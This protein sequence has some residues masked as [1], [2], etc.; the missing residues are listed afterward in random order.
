[1]AREGPGLKSRSGLRSEVPGD[2]SAGSAGVALPRRSARLDRVITFNDILHAGRSDPRRVKL[3]RHTVKGKQVLE[4][5]RADRALVEGYQRRQPIGFFEGVDHAACFLASRDGHAVFGGLYR[6]EGSVPVP[7]DDRDPL[8]GEPNQ[9]RWAIFDLIHEPGFAPYEDRL[10]VDWYAGG[11]HPGYWE[12]ADRNPKPIAEITTQREHPFPGW[13]EFSCPVDDL[14]LLPATWRE[15]LRSTSG[16][17]LLTDAT[18]KHYVG[19]AKGGNGFLGRWDAYRGGRSG[20]NLGLAGATGPFT[21]SVLQTFD[22]STS[23]QTVERVESLWKIS[24]AQNSSA[25]TGTSYSAP[26]SGE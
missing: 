8:T 15:V 4:L 5:W 17:Y 21:V 7:P 9:G 20:G 14:D 2:C 18:S 16:V 10:V 3:L 26:W 23:E 13:L 24:S 12:W 19:S 22:A 6:V 1:M 11:P 25:T